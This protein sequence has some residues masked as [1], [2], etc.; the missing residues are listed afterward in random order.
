MFLFPIGLAPLGNAAKYSVAIL[1]RSF[2]SW[3]WLVAILGFG[4]KYLNFNNE[5][6][7]YAREAVLPFYV[8]HQTIIVVI[9]FYI[10]NWETSVMVKYLILSTSSF[11][12][13]IAMYDLLIKRFS[14]LRFIFGMKVKQ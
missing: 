5:I 4:S 7:K 3:F 12:M 10:V 14:L 6:L 8:L 1:F 9:G 11:I 2:N 13:I